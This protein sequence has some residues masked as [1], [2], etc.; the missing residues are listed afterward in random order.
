[1]AN[2][3]KN[4]VITPNVNSASDNPKIVFS[5][6]DA[7]TG[8]QN[9]TMRTYV[10]NSPGTSASGILAFEGSN[11]QLMSIGSAITGS[12]FSANDRSGFPLIEVYDNCNV[13]IAHHGIGWLTYQRNPCFFVRQS[14]AGSGFAANAVMT[15]DVQ[16]M[17]NGG[18]FNNDRF[19]AP[20]KGIYFF[21]CHA[22][23]NAGL[24]GF[25]RFRVNGVDIA[26]TWTETYAPTNNWLDTQT[27]MV[28]ELNPG[29]YVQTYAA[30]NAHYGGSWAHFL[31]FQVG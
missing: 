25:I 29:D 22:S 27:N 11:G 20:W 16:E 17:N 12:V 15:W 21:S 7:S 8:P 13:D 14:V 23:N 19:T 18:F 6:A 1:M 3:D 28:F 10:A 30:N 4:I 24:R 31:G 2:S 26:G 9:I 5:G